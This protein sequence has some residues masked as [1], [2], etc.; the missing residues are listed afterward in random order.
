MRAKWLVAV[1]LIVL[2]AGCGGPQA[3]VPIF[4]MST[5]GISSDVGDKIQASLQGKLGE[6]PTVKIN[7]VPLFSMEKLVVEIAAGD[8]GIIIIPNEQFLVMVKQNGC[9]SLD[10]VAKAEDFPEGVQEAGENGKTEK[11][12]YGIP[13]EKVKLMTDLKLNGKDLVAFI[14]ANAKDK[15]KSLQ[16]M[17]MIAQK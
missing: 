1:M 2:L 15:E 11:H 13:L 4:M 8:N 12:L 16:V 5:N 17:K 10:N 3:D 14:P 7:T 6:K 9:V